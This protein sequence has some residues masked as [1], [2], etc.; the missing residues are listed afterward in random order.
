[1]VR[2]RKKCNSSSVA[3]P[4]V[5]IKDAMLKGATKEMDPREN[6]SISKPFL[7]DRATEAKYRNCEY[8]WLEIW[9]V[10]TLS[11][12]TPCE[13]L[14]RRLLFRP[15]G[16]HLH[17]SSNK[18]K[19]KGGLIKNFDTLSDDS[20]IPLYLILL[21]ETRECRQKFAVIRTA[22][23]VKKERRSQSYTLW[24]AS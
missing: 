13:G 17:V 20:L 6:R 11:T 3:A 2:K 9:F 24:R 23:A 22:G 18:E 21:S 7:L 8:D 12:G 15:I 1:M 4:I 16:I 19:K 10:R 14:S 5:R